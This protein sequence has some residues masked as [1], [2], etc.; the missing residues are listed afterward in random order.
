MKRLSFLRI[1]ILFLFIV[2]SLKLSAETYRY[3]TTAFTYS[4]SSSEYWEPWTYSELYVDMNTDSNIV[5]IHSNYLQ[6][7]YL[8]KSYGESSVGQSRYITFDFIDQDNDRG[9]LRMVKSPGKIMELYIEYADIKWC[10]RIK[11]LK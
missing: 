7:Y 10:Y 9:I 8:I 2:F 11:Q 4:E 1:L 3:Y 6:V 5:V